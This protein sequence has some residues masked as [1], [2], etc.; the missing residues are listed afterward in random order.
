MKT[1]YKHPLQITDKQTIKIAK[2]SIILSTAIQRGQFCIWYACDTR[3]KLEEISIY[4]FGTGHKIENDF[5]GK[6][7]GTVLMSEDDL[8]W[9]VFQEI[10]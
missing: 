6:F 9:H 3:N 1:I 2:G 8:V 10:K 5:D 4:I 7:I